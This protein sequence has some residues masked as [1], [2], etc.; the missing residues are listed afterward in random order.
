[1]SKSLITRKIHNRKNVGNIGKG[2]NRFKD[3]LISSFVRSLLERSV[4][5]APILR[6][7]H[8]S[9]IYSFQAVSADQDRR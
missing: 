2:Q 3:G 8:R 5:F 1:M 7:H 6:I 4:L 9:Q